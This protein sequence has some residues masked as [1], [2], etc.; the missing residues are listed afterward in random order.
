[1]LLT[2]KATNG[3]DG[4][5]ILPRFA[6]EIYYNCSTPTQNMVLYNNLYR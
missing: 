1:M 3:Y 5:S 2:T 6:T 4:Y